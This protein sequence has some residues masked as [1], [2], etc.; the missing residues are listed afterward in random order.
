MKNNSFLLVLFIYLLGFSSHS[1]AESL[2]FTSYEPGDHQKIFSGDWQTNDFM[3]EAKFQ[4]SSNA[5]APLIIYNPGWGGSEKYLSAFRDIRSKLG[6]K[7][8]HLF[9][10]HS[11][12][13]D[14]AGRTVTIY[15]AIR[16]IV[17]SGINPSKIGIVGASGGGQ[18]AMHTTH[19]KTALAL[20]GG[21]EIDAVVAFYPSCRVSFEDIKFNKVNTLIF[22]GL[23]D[24]VAPPTL[25]FELQKSHG[26]AHV[27]IHEYPN[28]GHS[29]LMENKKKNKKQ[30]TWGECRISISQAGV[31]RGEG[32]DSKDGIGK[33]LKGM[34]K[35]CAK[36]KSM[37][38]GRDPTVYKDSIQLTVEFIGKM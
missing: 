30:R 34:G 19:Q 4:R 28:A 17:E 6:N 29:W 13:V 36:K 1:S 11:D 15:Q 2:K 10:S 3:A 23:K 8:H 31:W 16:A 21:I 18:E 27:E 38:V 37:L 7:Y 14:L 9:L 5:Q 32:F 33:L 35:K 25:C 22:V 24:K 26:L 12:S 20:S